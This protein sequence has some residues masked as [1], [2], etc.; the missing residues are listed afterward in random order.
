MVQFRGWMPSA[1]SKYYTNQVERKNWWEAQ[2]QNSTTKMPTDFLVLNAGIKQH[3]EHK[4]LRVFIKTATVMRAPAQ[5]WRLESPL[6]SKS[7][8]P[9]SEKISAGYQLGSQG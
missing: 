6:V 9:Q 8:V 3:E 2:I 1:G 4:G 5:A 7:G